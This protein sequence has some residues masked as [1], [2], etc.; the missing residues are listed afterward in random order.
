VTQNCTKSDFLQLHIFITIRHQM[1]AK[2][3]RALDVHI[4]LD[5]GYRTGYWLVARTSITVVRFKIY[6]F[7]MV[8][9]L[10]RRNNLL[11]M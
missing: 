5:N 4:L 3:C 11:Y 6:I 8:W 9:P 10:A 1:H 7:A 2:I